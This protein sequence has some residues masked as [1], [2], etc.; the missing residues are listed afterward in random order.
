MEE[1]WE[2]NEPSAR[3]S[4]IAGWALEPNRSRVPLLCCDW[5]EPNQLTWEPNKTMPLITETSYVTSIDGQ[6]AEL[7][8]Y[9]RAAAKKKVPLLYCQ[10]Q[11]QTQRSL[12]LIPHTNWYK[13]Q[14]PQHAQDIKF[15]KHTERH[16][17][18]QKSILYGHPGL[19]LQTKHWIVQ[20]Y[21]NDKHVQV[22]KY[23]LLRTCCD[24]SRM[25]LKSAISAPR[26]SICGLPP[27]FGIP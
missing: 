10:I 19:K 22:Q 2:P 14:T 23:W 26:P 7:R 12:N 18:W 25:F 3:S 17:W 5:L 1:T 16:T 8:V 9:I 11:F 13:T 15:R 4:T 27:L 6:A 24:S 20:V 21:A